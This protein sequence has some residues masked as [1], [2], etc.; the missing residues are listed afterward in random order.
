MIARSCL[1][2][3]ACFALV[4][5]GVSPVPA[6]S[7]YE[8]QLYKNAENFGIV[9]FPPPGA[10]DALSQYIDSIGFKRVDGGAAVMRFDKGK[11]NGTYMMPETV[12]RKHGIEKFFV[13][14]I[15]SLN[16]FMIGVFDPQYGLTLPQAIFQLDDFKKNIPR[17]LEVFRGEPVKPEQPD[18]KKPK[19]QE[20]KTIEPDKGPVISF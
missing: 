6:G 11:A 10:N 14:Q 9:V 20:P 12:Q 18:T 15:L 3:L 1:T 2:V 7:D 16:G 5:M 4:L 19:P 8:Y 17:T 13:V